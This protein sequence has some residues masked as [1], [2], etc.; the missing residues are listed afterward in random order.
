MSSSNKTT[1]RLYST[2]HIDDPPELEAEK[3]LSFA[4][5]SIK[6]FKATCLIVS[7]ELVLGTVRERVEV[8]LETFVRRSK[9]VERLFLD[10]VDRGDDELEIAWPG[11]TRFIIQKAMKIYD[12][13]F[14]VDIIM[15]ITSD[16]IQTVGDKLKEILVWA[17][18]S[19]PFLKR[20][21]FDSGLELACQL[22]DVCFRH[23]AAPKVGDNS[24]WVEAAR[25]C[26]EHNLAVPLKYV[27]Q[28]LLKWFQFL[29]KNKTLPAKNFNYDNVIDSALLSL[30]IK[31]K[32]AIKLAVSILSRKGQEWWR[33]NKKGRGKIF[34]QLTRDQ[35]E[36]L[37]PLIRAYPAELLPP[38][39]KESEIGNPLFAETVFLNFQNLRSKQR[40]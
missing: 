22:L 15:N 19:V 12:E 20:Y 21:E 23:W 37:K 35:V 39:R 32:D 9:L 10:A 25:L 27:P 24:L 3:Q 2:M 11:V 1:K 4:S 17:I 38:G 30:E 14:M 18:T 31:A 16:N 40:K 7:L 5:A 34:H 6:K 13:H 8:D 33:P 29:A 26:V 36:E 28:Y